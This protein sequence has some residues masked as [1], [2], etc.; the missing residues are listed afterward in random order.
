M[1]QRTSKVYIR[2][3]QHSMRHVRLF[4]A[5]HFCL[6]WTFIEVKI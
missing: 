1:E 4:T 5:F 3:R 6:I 2:I